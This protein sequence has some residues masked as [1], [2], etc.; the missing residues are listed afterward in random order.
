[1][2]Q[3]RW[4]FVAICCAIVFAARLAMRLVGLRAL[5]SRHLVGRGGE[6][7][8]PRAPSPRRSPGFRLSHV[9]MPLFLG[10]AIFFPAII[11]GG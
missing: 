9:M 3:Q 1:M 5:P 2:L 6:A 10:V 8:S 7:P 11:I 4:G